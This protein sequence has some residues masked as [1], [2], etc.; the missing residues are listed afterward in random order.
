MAGLFVA[1]PS[2]SLPG[3]ADRLV[4]GSH[5]TRRRNLVPHSTTQVVGW[6]AT[7][8]MVQCVARLPAPSRLAPADLQAVRPPPR[9][10]TALSALASPGGWVTGKSTI[11]GGAY[12]RI[13]AHT[14]AYSRILAHMVD[15]A[16]Q[17]RLP[18]SRWGRGSRLVHLA[19]KSGLGRE[20]TDG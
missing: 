13:L 12:S 19:Q 11:P 1:G 20:Q 10:L 14:R 5:P 16:I 9:G 2:R 18:R 8:R 4:G 17:R 15:H 3:W 6:I 7:S